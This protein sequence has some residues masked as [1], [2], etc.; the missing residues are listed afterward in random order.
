MFGFI[1]GDESSG[2]SK[3][4]WFF[5]LGRMATPISVAEGRKL[6]GRRVSFM[7]YTKEGK[8]NADNVVVLEERFSCCICTFIFFILNWFF[9]GTLRNE[10]HGVGR[11]RGF[12]VDL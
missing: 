2:N 8:K 12:T 7:T 9:V 11:K 10:I 5:H 1:K 6:T 4:N 3:D